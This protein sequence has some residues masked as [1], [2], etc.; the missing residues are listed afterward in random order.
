[1][2]EDKLRVLIDTNVAMTFLTKRKDPYTKEA[3]EV[4][5]FC[6]SEKII[7]FLAFHSLSTIWY[8]GRKLGVE[9]G[10]EMLE[11]V[12]NIL[13]VV[14][15]SQREVEK[16]IKN[17]DFKDFEDCLQDKCA[18]EAN[19]DYIVTANMKDFINSEVPAIA[20]D[21]LVKIFLQQ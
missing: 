1:M 15:A 14:G 17:R 13:N 8:L 2:N 20:P 21:E 9:K 5:F 4:M 12:C 11:T 3:E 16:A 19:C 7:G 18:K 10:R 6:A